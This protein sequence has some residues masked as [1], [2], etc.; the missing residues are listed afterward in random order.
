MLEIIFRLAS[1]ARTLGYRTVV[2][3]PRS[4]F[5]NEERFP[6]VDQLVDAWPQDA[7]PQ[8]TVNENTAVALLTH[9]STL[10]DPA[11]EI[12]LDS[13]AFYVGALG[14]RKTHADRIERLGTLGLTPAQIARIRG[15][16]GLNIGAQTPEEIALSI[17]AEIIAERHQRPSI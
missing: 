6:D 1:L 14:S 13:P 16:I 7:L 4:A 5:G 17:M 3:D 2:I 11:F 9:D 10:D 12:V 8:L 15:P